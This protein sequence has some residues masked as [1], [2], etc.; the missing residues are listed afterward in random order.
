MRY[1]LTNYEP[2]KRNMVIRILRR[3]SEC[4]LPIAHPYNDY[5]EVKYLRDTL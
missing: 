3:L 1:D 4:A 2:R 5:L